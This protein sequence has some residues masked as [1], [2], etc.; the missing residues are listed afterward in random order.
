MSSYIN[1]IDEQAE[2]ACISAL[3][4]GEDVA[5]DVLSNVRY[6]DFKHNENWRLV[7]C[8]EEL[9]ANKQPI[10]LLALQS[11]LQKENWFDLVGGK[12]FFNNLKKVRLLPENRIAF[13]DNL[14][15]FADIKVAAKRVKSLSNLQKISEI[16]SEVAKE[17][18][19]GK[20]DESTCL[21]KLRSLTIEMD[22]QQDNQAKSQAEDTNLM[23]DHFRMLSE[24]ISVA[25]PTGFYTYDFNTGGLHGGDLILLSGLHKGGKSI[26]G[27]KI[28]DNIVK[29]HVPCA[30]FSLEMSRKEINQRRLCGR[31]YEL[32]NPILFSKLRGG[33]SR[34][35]TEE[36]TKELTQTWNILSQ[37]PLYIADNIFT[38]TDILL[39]AERLIRRHNVKVIMLDYLQLVKGI[40]TMEE[41]ISA[42][43]RELK[44]L[45]N[46]F[47]DKGVS[48]IACNQLNKQGQGSARDFDFITSDHTFGSSAPVK[49]A[50]V[51]S[52]VNISDILYKCSGMCPETETTNKLISGKLLPVEKRVH[53]HR[54]ANGKCNRC[55]ADVITSEHREGEWVIEKARSCAGGIKS[56]F[57]FIGKYMDIQEVIPQEIEEHMIGGLFN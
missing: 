40:G 51:I 22:Y 14:G 29:R 49:D 28:I 45:A 46:M 2:F 36:Q 13:D 10:T 15:Q 7:K 43:T 11:I 44:I 41:R 50:T 53:K 6:T 16:S 33:F 9:V 52:Y 37:E 34:T 25:E 56:E 19:L 54:P 3:Q 31:M 20:V 48:V 38:I 42:T 8:A 35:I 32:G 47:A 5:L 30:I 27:L 17:S 23:L 12:L 26:L 18:R 1:L 4:F 39:E 55:G 21:S 57:Q 24:G